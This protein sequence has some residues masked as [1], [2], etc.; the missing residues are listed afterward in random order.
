MMPDSTPALTDYGFSDAFQRLLGPKQSKGLLDAIQQSQ[1]LQ[2]L[3]TA[4][5]HA[6]NSGGI[7]LGAAHGGTRT[8]GNSTSGRTIYIDPSLFQGNPSL[9][10]LADV[11]AHELGHAIEG[12]SGSDT[13]YGGDGNNTIIGGSGNSTLVAANGPGGTL[14]FAGANLEQNY[15]TGGSGNDVIFGSAG[16]AHP[17]ATFEQIVN[18]CQV[19]EI[20]DV[21]ERLPKGY[22]TEIGERGVGLSGGQKRRLAIARA[23]IKQPKSLFSTKP[24]VASTSPLPNISARPSISSGGKSR[25]SSL[26][27]HCL[28]I[29]RSMRSC[30]SG[31]RASLR[32]RRS[33]P[34]GGR[35][36]AVVVSGILL[37]WKLGPMSVRLIST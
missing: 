21:I 32:P 12:G 26:H 23:L 20:H 31:C 6:P 14:A 17:H 7:Q 35:R 1:L 9:P 8:V 11:L 18:A 30:R 3:L 34:S 13:L 15:V 10:K 19:A 16:T 25:C 2:S 29:C 4:F 28:R 33:A 27:M 22:Q 5:F 36:K 37:T 24:P